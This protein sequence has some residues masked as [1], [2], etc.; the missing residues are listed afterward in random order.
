MLGGRGA[1]SPLP[2]PLCGPQAKIM[3]ELAR[4]LQADEEQ[5]GREPGSKDVRESLSSRVITVRGRVHVAPKLR[6]ALHHSPA[7]HEPQAVTAPQAPALPSGL[8][9]SPQPRGSFGSQDP[10]PSPHPH[11]FGSCDS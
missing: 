11:H 9:P 5:W 7:P 6:S 1:T 10:N 4:E 8:G 2:T 3:A